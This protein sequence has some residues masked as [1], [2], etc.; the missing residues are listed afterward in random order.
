MT[1]E[2]PY[3]TASPTSP[4]RRPVQREDILLVTVGLGA[5]ALLCIGMA[6]LQCAI[7]SRCKIVM[8]DGI[9]LLGVQLTGGAVLGFGAY[10]SLR[11]HGIP[12]VGSMKSFLIL[13][14][15]CWILAL[16][17]MLG[18]MEE[19]GLVAPEAQRWVLSWLE[20]N[21]GGLSK[22]IGLG[23]ASLLSAHL[24]PLVLRRS[25]CREIPPAPRVAPG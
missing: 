17:V 22:V 20:D 3:R 24:L 10:W 12:G 2:N 4:F 14:Q 8:P 13:L 21:P 23:V 11:T 7:W 16:M 18:E 9:W 25:I 19:D 15:L 1:Q 5:S 6:L